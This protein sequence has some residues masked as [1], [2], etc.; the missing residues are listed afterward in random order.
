M[1]RGMG[2]KWKTMFVWV[3]SLQKRGKK[4]KQKKKETVRSSFYRFILGKEKEEK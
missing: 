3:K 2:G 1:R 4:K